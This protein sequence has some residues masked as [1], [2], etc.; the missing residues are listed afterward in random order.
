MFKGYLY[1]LYTVGILFLTVPLTLI[2]AQPHE[3]LLGGSNVVGN[4]FRHCASVRLDKAHICGG[5]II[6]ERAIL[7]AAHCL[8]EKGLKCVIQVVVYPS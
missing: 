1:F 4:L 7:T 5:S 3:R 6:G 8:M 2:F